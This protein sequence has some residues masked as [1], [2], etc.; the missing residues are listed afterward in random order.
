[1]TSLR[2]VAVPSAGALLLALS[3]GGRA[4]PGVDAGADSGAWTPCSSPSGF[5][6]CGGP[7]RC[8]PTRDS[9]PSQAGKDCNCI[10]GLADDVALCGN[11]AYVRFKY[12]TYGAD[13]FND[14]PCG[15]G[16]VLVDISAAVPV[17]GYMCLP[18][19]VG[20]LFDRA[21]AGARVR[22]ADASLWTGAPV[23]AAAPSCPGPF[24]GLTY[25][26]G[27]CGACATDQIC[28]GLSPTHPVGF[29]F[30][31]TPSLLD[32][33][34]RRAKPAGDDC[35]TTPGRSCFNFTVEP[36][37]QPLADN[38]GY[39]LPDASCADAAMKLG[40]TCTP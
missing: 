13:V 15:D 30:K 38:L 3:C 32:S 39:C 8:P 31:R 4:G 35:A 16:N 33:D 6:I 23:P 37:A 2:G 29:C 18:R 5:A 9:P 11:D 20:E 36:A 25:C 28:V 26:G 17:A 19:E 1:M 34:C 21:G 40:G 12:G 24:A 22:Y 10:D 27:G 7:A 14:T